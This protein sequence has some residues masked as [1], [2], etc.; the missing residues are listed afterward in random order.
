MTLLIDIGNTRVKWRFQSLADGMSSG[1]CAHASPDFRSSLL[2]AWSAFKP[3]TVLI[4]CVGPDST[5]QTV[6][7]VSAALFGAVPIHEARSLA[8]LGGLIT[9]YPQPERLGVDRFLALLAAHRRHPRDQLIVGVG[10]ALTVDALQGDGRHRGGLIA[11]APRLMQQSLVDA[12]A[13]IRPWA[14]GAL[15][16]FAANTEDAIAGGAWHA[17]AGLVERACNRSRLWAPGGVALVLHGGDAVMLA[18]LLGQPAELVQDL[19]LDGLSDYGT[20]RK[21]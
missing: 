7:D 3:T 15:V 14:S 13:G 12:T 8:E 10:T 11:P 1:A 16:D 6:R 4:S 9:A 20:L 21:L 5:R 19:V 17:A 18:S 2:A